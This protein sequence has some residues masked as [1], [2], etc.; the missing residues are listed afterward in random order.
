MKKT[1]VM[2]LVFVMLV[3]LS[4]CGNNASQATTPGNAGQ[5][6]AEGAGKT[7]EGTEGT[8]GVT[9]ASTE[10]PTAASTEEAI[11]AATT[12]PAEEPTEAPTAPP[13]EEI[14]H[15]IESGTAYAISASVGEL[16][17]YVISAEE[18]RYATYSKSK[19]GYG[20]YEFRE[21]NGTTYY[22][23][24]PSWGGFSVSSV[25]ISG[26]TVK[27]K[28]GPETLE[29]ELISANKYKVTKGVGSIP[30]GLVLTIGSN[31]CS[32]LGHLYS[33]RCIDDITCIRC[34]QYK[35]AGFDHEYG[36]DD[37]CF[38]CFAAMRPSEEPDDPGQ[39]S[40]PSEGSGDGSG[41]GSGDG[42]GEGSG[43]GSGEGSGDGSG[44][45]TGD[46]SGEGTGE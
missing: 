41:E 26:K 10:E 21:H 8:T 16:T 28:A 24:A 34:G 4:A 14:Y 22:T 3:S 15:P 45:G 12:A 32:Q 1:L 38:R 17:C 5:A 29:L 19:P 37:I 7:T 2:I 46:G 44:E 18:A 25:T 11:A 20:Y 6:A 35:C 31:T 9:T 39:E 43:D 33:V 23:S 13:T 36:D 42:S 27:L 30:S 40:E